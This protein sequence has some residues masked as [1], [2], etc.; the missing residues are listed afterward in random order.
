MSSAAGLPASASAIFCTVAASLESRAT[1]VVSR[2][3]EGSS[4]TPLVF[5]PSL[6]VEYP[7]AVAADSQNAQQLVRRLS[8]GL[9]P[10]HDHPSGMG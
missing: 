3:R 7:Q 4:I 5:S 6:T 10:L 8:T 9:A 1:T 2:L